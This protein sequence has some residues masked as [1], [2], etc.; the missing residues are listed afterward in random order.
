MNYENLKVRDPELFHAM[1]LELERQRNHIE[2]IASENFTSQA[3][4]EA[5]G[6][7]LTNKYAEG[8][9]GARYYGGCQYVDMVERLAI[10]RVTKLFGAE[11]ANVQP[12]SGAQANIA[13]YAALL[14]PGDK[15]LG[16][17]L[18]HGGH[19]THGS[20]AS[21]SGKYFEAHFYGV[22]PETETI[23]YDALERTAKE[24]QPKLIIAGAS[25]Y[26]RVID[27]AR[28][29][30]IADEVGAYLMVDMAHIGGLV[31]AGVHPSPVPYADVVTC[32]THKTLRG[33]RGAIILCRDELA[34]KIDSAVF[35]GTQGGPLMHVIA[36]KAVCFGEALQPEFKAYQQQVVA[37]ASVLAESLQ[38]GGVRLVSGGTDNHLMLADVFSRGRTGAEVQELLDR[39]HITA[40][41]NTIP[42]D[43]QSVRTTSGMRF[44][45]PAATTRGMKEA[46]MRA[47]GAMI[48]RLIDEGDAAVPAVRDEVIALCEQ[49]PLYPGL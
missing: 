8:Y 19:L 32:T 43:T 15:I 34:K 5:M 28:F 40:N 42:F 10:E 48:C 45:T 30:A 47:I 38:Q 3:V 36:G 25:A 7:H 27:F 26:P 35:P 49:F 29:R 4:M 41:K 24:V 39:A 18:S 14:K 21:I 46:Q 2:L 13:V 20:K 23:D 22:D 37:N 1:E 9:P 12:H 33:P 11:H 16:M 44:G 31:A 17:D 6:S